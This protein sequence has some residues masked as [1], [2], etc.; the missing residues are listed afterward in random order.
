MAAYGLM[1]P[2]VT[3]TNPHLPPGAMGSPGVGLEEL[4]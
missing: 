4:D 2:Y 1:G 3:P